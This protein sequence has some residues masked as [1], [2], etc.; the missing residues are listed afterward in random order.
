MRIGELANLAGVSPRTIDYYTQIGLI[1]E[2][3]RSPGKHRL[4]AG[5]SLKTIRIVKELQKQHYSLEEI[6]H[7]FSGQE[8]GDLFKRIVAV[9]QHLDS[10]QKEVAELYP[11]IRLSGADEEV[12]VVSRELT[13]KGRQVLQA[14]MVLLGEPIV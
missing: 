8:N 12:R 14:L 6:C 7:L 9:R 4:Y 3:A 5:E 10:L 11:A 1:H 13:N 2:A